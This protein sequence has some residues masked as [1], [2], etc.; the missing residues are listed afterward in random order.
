MALQI[1]SVGMLDW[2]ATGRDVFFVQIN[3]QEVMFYEA[4]RDGR[5]APVVEGPAPLRFVTASIEKFNNT[6]RCEKPVPLAR[7]ED[8]PQFIGRFE[9]TS[10]TACRYVP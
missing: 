8:L 9:V 6:Y 10:D 2:Q 3:D 7:V 4:F 5:V 1:L